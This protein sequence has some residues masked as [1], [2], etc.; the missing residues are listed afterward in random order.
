MP[1]FE[2]VCGSC[3]CEFEELKTSRDTTPVA[4]KNCG[5][6]AELKMSRF[7]SVIAGGSS[8]DTADKV[9]G[10]LA[11][12]RWQMYHDRQ[13]Q[14]HGNIPLTPIDVPQENGRYQPV[15][16]LGDNHDRSKRKEFVTALKE[17]TQK[18]LEKSQP[19]LV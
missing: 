17:D 6:P 7:A 11:N 9:V 3:S 2:Y 8:N 4:C 14:R 12:E 15:M 18:K 1:I 5:A 10:R 19:A 13:K 16:A